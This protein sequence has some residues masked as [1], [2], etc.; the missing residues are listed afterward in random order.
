MTHSDKFLAEL[1]LQCYFALFSFD[2]MNALLNNP[3]GIEDMRFYNHRIWHALHGVLISAANI[4]KILW[5]HRNYAARGERLRQQLGVS[6]DSPLRS[7]SLRD[8]FEHV[9]ERIE[10]WTGPRVDL[11]I[12][13]LEYQAGRPPFRHFD[14]SAGAVLF[15]GERYDLPAVVDAIQHLLQK[16]DA[17]DPYP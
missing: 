6:D 9:D 17:L 12:G 3:P 11:N 4:S 5:P 14:P 15:A 10:K 2:D 7:R 1:Q 8:H 16:L 13:R